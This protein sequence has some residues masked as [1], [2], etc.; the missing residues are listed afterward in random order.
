[1]HEMHEDPNPDPN[2]N[3]SPDPDQVREMHEDGKFCI[4]WDPLDGRSTLIT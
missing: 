2:P 1:M 4:C 3:P